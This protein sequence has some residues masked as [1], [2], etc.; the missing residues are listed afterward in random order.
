MK[1]QDKAGSL[2]PKPINKINLLD[3]GFKHNYKD[4]PQGFV[5]YHFGNYSYSFGVSGNI[6]LHQNQ[7][8]VIASLIHIKT[9]QELDQF[10]KLFTGNTITNG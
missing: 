8:G 5:S 4:H 7:N 9:I 2:L 1:P 3:I 10:H 6:N